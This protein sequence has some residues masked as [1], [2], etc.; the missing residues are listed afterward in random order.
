MI[1]R[2]ISRYNGEYINETFVLNISF[3]NEIITDIHNF[4]KG[5]KCNYVFKVNLNNLFIGS[6]S[7]Y[8]FTY[9]KDV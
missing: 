1:R 8:T 7:I 3:F 6:D 5:I 9:R 2:F 4:S